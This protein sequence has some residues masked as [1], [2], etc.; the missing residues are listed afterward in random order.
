[1]V[2]ALQLPLFLRDL[3]KLT[4]ERSELRKLRINGIGFGASF[5]HSVFCLPVAVLALPL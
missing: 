2:P 4:E 5:W 3:E 1:L